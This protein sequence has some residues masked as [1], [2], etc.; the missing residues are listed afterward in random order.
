[1]TFLHCNQRFLLCMNLYRGGHFQMQRII[2]WNFNHR[3]TFSQTCES[4]PSTSYIDRVMYVCCHTCMT[5]R[6]YIAMH[7]RHTIAYQYTLIPTF[8]HCCNLCARVAVA[9]KKF[10]LNIANWENKS[11][12][13]ETVVVWASLWAAAPIG[14]EVCEAEGCSPNQR[15][16][17]ANSLSDISSR[18]L[19]S[20][21]GVPGVPIFG[22]GFPPETI[23]FDS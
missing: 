7:C 5:C 4:E 23:T 6:A 21:P 22:S 12:A 3:N 19:L 16:Q 8:P 9:S 10:C 11:G 20:D 2:V 17:S 1:M 18:Q 15:A 14:Q 13:L